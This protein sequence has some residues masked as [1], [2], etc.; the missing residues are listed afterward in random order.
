MRP[1]GPRLSCG[2]PKKG[3]FPNLR[4][5]SASSAWLGVPHFGISMTAVEPRIPT[6]Q[7][8]WV[9]AL[10]HRPQQ[11]WHLPPPPDDL[12]SALHVPKR[13]LHE[14]LDVVNFSVVF[15]AVGHESLEVLSPLSGIRTGAGNVKLLHCASVDVR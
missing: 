6:L 12:D 5:P 10:R 3:S 14:I 15:C 7:G 8:W 9:A 11:A 4:A 1:N 2:A 13:L